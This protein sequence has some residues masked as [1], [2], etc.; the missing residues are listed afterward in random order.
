MGG[1]MS[2]S[3]GLL[4][5]KERGGKEMFVC[6]ENLWKENRKRSRFVWFYFWL[7]KKINPFLQFVEDDLQF[8]PR[9][10]YGSQIDPL[11]PNQLRFQM[12]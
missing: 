3:Y 1:G 8:L 6:V 10:V 2:S 5:T 4:R 7:Y 9:K 11:I 12:P